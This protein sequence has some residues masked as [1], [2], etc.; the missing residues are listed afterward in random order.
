MSRETAGDVRTESVIV[1]SVDERAADVLGERW[2]V[3]VEEGQQ[4]LNGTDGSTVVGD[5]DRTWLK[6]DGSASPALVPE[7]FVTSNGTVWSLELVVDTAV[8][9][10][11]RSPILTVIALAVAT[12]LLAAAD[13]TILA[14]GGERGRSA[15]GSS[16]RSV[17]GGSH[18]LA[19]RARAC[20]HRV[21][22]ARRCQSRSSGA[23]RALRA[24]A[25]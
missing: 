9:A 11:S 21:C 13:I 2:A 8:P 4:W 17:C 10:P 19:G 14:A 5:I 20:R 1:G 23:L 6:L 24:S 7:R 22:A 18:S 25:Q 12:L 3:V 16:R 15:H